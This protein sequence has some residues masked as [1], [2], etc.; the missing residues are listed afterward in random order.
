[1]NI[2]NAIIQLC[3]R[4]TEA[5]FGGQLSAAHQL[6]RQAWDEAG[7]DYEACVAAHY[8][9]HILMRQE[10]PVA[11]QLQWHLE[12]LRRAELVAD[13]RVAPFYLSLYVNLRHCYALL[14][15]QEAAERYAELAS[16]LDFGG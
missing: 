8:L 10:F 7:D 16:L 14:G 12:A 13:E 4:G 6:Y 15:D 2:D 11:E 1:M 5:E 9:G 3:L